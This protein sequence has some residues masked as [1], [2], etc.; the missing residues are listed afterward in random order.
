M[1][2]QDLL[3]GCE[4]A[5]PL[6]ELLVVWESHH[7]YRASDN[8]KL[9]EGPLIYIISKLCLRE[10][11]IAHFGPSGQTD[12]SK[13]VLAIGR[14]H[15]NSAFGHDRCLRWDPFWDPD[16]LGLGGASK[17]NLGDR[18]KCTNEPRALR[19]CQ[20]IGETI[21]M[22][23]LCLVAEFV[24]PCSHS[25]LIPVCYVLLRNASLIGSS[26]MSTLRIFLQWVEKEN[27]MT[28]HNSGMYHQSM[29]YCR[30]FKNS[31]ID[32]GACHLQ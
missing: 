31:F 6:M 23:E 16:Y 27:I 22:F 11:W 7:E 9:V 13:F 1:T 25:I 30:T 8:L 12:L 5:K 26:S 20:I 10:D 17:P 15:D 18:N 4:F 28:S 3:A 2:Y 24:P 14:I 32:N 19:I 29:Y 21:P